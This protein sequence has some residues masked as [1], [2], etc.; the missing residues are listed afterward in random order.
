MDPAGDQKVKSP[1]VS[2]SHLYFIQ[3]SFHLSMWRFLIF[4]S[5]FFAENVRCSYQ[6]IKKEIEVFITNSELPYQ[7]K[8]GLQELLSTGDVRSISKAWVRFAEP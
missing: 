3:N 7:L 1:T 4:W 5:L 6:R 2:H 8:S